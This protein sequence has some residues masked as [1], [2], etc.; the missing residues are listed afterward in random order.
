MS[1][2]IPGAPAPE[3]PKPSIKETKRPSFSY[4]DLY[5]ADSFTSDGRKFVTFFADVKDTP[6]FVTFTRSEF[7]EYQR[8]FFNLYDH[9][10]ENE[11]CSCDNTTPTDYTFIEDVVFTT[12]LTKEDGE[13]ETTEEKIPMYSLFNPV[14]DLKIGMHVS[15]NIK[16]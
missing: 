11:L 9:Q 2:N 15:H 12:I 13:T 5:L 6:H 14:A 16:E 7:E 3:T 1:D 8:E 10:L 4:F